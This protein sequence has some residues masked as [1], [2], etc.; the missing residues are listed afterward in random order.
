MVNRIAPDTT[1]IHRKPNSNILLCQPVT[2]EYGTVHYRWGYTDL[3][4][5]DETVMPGDRN[6]CLYDIGIDTLSYL[7][8][9]ETYLDSPVGE[10]CD[11]RSYY[12]HSVLTSTSDYDANTV[13]AYM[14]NNHIMLYVNALS[15]DNVL[16][17]LYDVNGKLL[18]TRGY[19]ITDVVSDAIAVNIVPGVYFLSVSVGNEFYSF[20]LLKL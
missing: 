8:W 19:G 5:Y 12:G 11:N 20:K 10:G 1:E 16:T 7:Y 3:L 18:L 17:S 9:V 14:S 15:P 13:E 4:T 2:S 6:Y